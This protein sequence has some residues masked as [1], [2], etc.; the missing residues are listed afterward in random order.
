MQ[1]L[2][3]DDSPFSRRV[4]RSELEQGGY[5]V[6]EAGSGPEALDAVRKRKPDLVTLDVSMQQMDGYE[7]CL[8]LRGQFQRGNPGETTARQIPIIFI[9]GDDSVEGR[10]R[11]FEVGAMDFVA[12][13]FPPGR[14]RAKVDALLRQAAPWEGV[15]ALVVDDSE[16][17]RAAVGDAL[18]RHGMEVLEA[19]DGE[20][21]RELARKE[22]ERLDVVIVDYLMPGMRGDDFARYLRSE[23]GLTELPIIMLSGMSDRSAV[24]D[25]F[26]AGVS[27]YLVKPFL[28]EELMARLGVHLR[29][30]RLGRSLQQKVAELERLNKAKSE[31][32]GVTSHDLRSPL[33]SILGYSHLLAS[34]D[35]EQEKRNRFANFI[36]NAGSQLT[37][38]ID[39]LIQVSRELSVETELDLQPLQPWEV[40]T[41][42]VDAMGE[43]ARV[44]RI[45]VETQ[46]N[47]SPDAQI[48]ADGTGMARVLNNLLSNAIKFTPEGGSVRV[49]MGPGAGG[50][51]ELIVTDTGVG[52]ARENREALFSLFSP[53]TQQGTAG[54]RGSGLGLG[55]VKKLVEKQHGTLALD[56]TPG[57]G[58]TVRLSFPR[59]DDATAAG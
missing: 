39:S 26:R 8:L 9:T 45:T 25:M 24:I 56:S 58:T 13:P 29:A 32:L 48:L 44:K 21:G 3:V 51:L 17:A 6:V 37:G 19:E 20:S 40:V 2:V 5:E 34:T 35:L 52:I 1:I 59:L 55:I 16:I 27:D 50:T 38:L 7:T 57:R 41:A 12:K 53:H 36:E 22:A 18:R 49:E 15:T 11:G 4:I 10:D 42:A 54:E 23:L 28:S 47:L 14:L 31:F 33:Q 30:F 43:M 46:P